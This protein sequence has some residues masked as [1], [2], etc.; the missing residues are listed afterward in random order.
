MVDHYIGEMLL[1][2]MLIEEFR[3]FCGFIHDVSR[4]FQDQL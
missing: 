1:N 4:K 3:T 2:F